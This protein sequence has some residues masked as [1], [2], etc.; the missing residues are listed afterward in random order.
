MDERG[1]NDGLDMDPLI[2]AAAGVAKVA[3]A[4]NTLANNTFAHNLFG[5]ITKAYGD[6]WGEQAT[7]RLK[8]KLRSAAEAK[9][10]KNLFAHLR[11]VEGLI[12]QEFNP[13]PTLSQ[14]WVAG[15][16][17]V[18]PQDAEL[19]AAW[20]GVLLAIGDGESQRR[21]LLSVVQSLSPE[22]AH[23]FMSMYL[24][25]ESGFEEFDTAHRSRLEA[26]GLLIRPLEILTRGR[27]IFF[28]VAPLVVIPVSVAVFNMLQLE[29]QMINPRLF[30]IIN[31]MFGLKD[32]YLML[33][34]LYI[35]TTTSILHGSFYN[36]E[37]TKLGRT[38]GYFA[39]RA[40]VAG[41]R[42]ATTEQETASPSEP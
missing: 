39:T 2:T 11:A 14:E 35:C 20:R 42:G 23:A 13:D 6:H 33:F 40:M 21:R 36:I 25:K 12:G 34:Y 19:A 28:L 16:E 4:A 38:L 30:E 17:R 27:N 37:I 9:K 15:A 18:D 1:A 32:R 7:V 24:P 5:P 31:L 22:E 26:L 10:T 3:G 29:H 41:G 8:E